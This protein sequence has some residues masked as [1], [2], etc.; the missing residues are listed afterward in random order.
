MRFQSIYKKNIL[1]IRSNERSIIPEINSTK[2]IGHGLLSHLC[3]LRAS[4]PQVIYDHTCKING[5]WLFKGLHT[6]FLYKSSFDVYLSWSF[7]YRIDN[8]TLKFRLSCSIY[9][10]QPSFCVA[11]RC[12]S[13]K[14]LHSTA[15][16]VF[17]SVI[18]T[19]GKQFI[20]LPPK[21]P[22]KGGQWSYSLRV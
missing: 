10:R 5:G 3:T 19:Q 12:T 21:F 11:Y 9:S 1:Y 15:D 22:W 4:V 14:V 18:L 20:V 13:T 17:Y 8:E 7:S 6:Y 2:N 16:T